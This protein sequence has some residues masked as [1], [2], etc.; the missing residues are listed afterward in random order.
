M[1]VAIKQHLKG[2]DIKERIGAGG[3]GAVYKAFQSTVGR[4]VAIKIILPG[5]SNQPDFIRRFESEAQ[6]IAR[7]EHPHI[8]PLYD[9]W[10]DPEGAYLVMRWLRGGSLR[11]ALQNGAFE[12]HATA[13]LLDQ[14]A[15]ALSLAHRNHIIHRDIK[16]ANILLDEDGNAYLTDFGIAKDLN[17]A[18]N[19]T[20]AD[21]IVGSLD[22]ISP[23][24]ARSEPVTPR[25]DIY[26]LGV[27]LYEV[28]SG[29]HPFEN[30]SPI[31][32]LYKHINDPLPEITTLD[33]KI[34]REINR[35]IQ[36][37]TAKDPEQR[38]PD[39]LAFAADF[40]EA[41]G[42]NRTPTDVIE[43]LT[44]RE[45]EILQLI[46]DGLS[47]KEIAQKLTI[48]LSTVK[49][50]VYQIYDK[51]GVRSRV[52]AM[53][54]ARDLNLLAKAGENGTAPVPT[55]DFHP[56][57]PY[58]GLRAFQSADNQD[59]F[60]R[61]KVTAKLI[62]RL[63]EASDY[64]RF[65][66]VVGPSGSG[67]SS[68]VKAGLIPALWRG[69]LPGSEKWFVVEMLPGTRPLDELEIALTKVAA[70]QA[71]NLHEHLQ[72]DS[73]GL[74]RA[75]SLILPNDNSELVLVID[76]FEEVF[77][78]L[79]DETAR[80][81]LLELLYRAVTEPRSRVRVVITLR[82]D[83]YDRPLH[84]P[85]FGELVRTRLETIM[86]LSAEELERAITQPA[87]R[88]GVIFEAGLV[89]AIIGD[90]NYQPGALPLLQY[91]LTELFEQRKGRLLT[92]EAYQA[93]GGT[94][95]ALAKR[96]EEV[97]QQLDAD[98]QE[99]TR[100]MFL[101]L[102]TL[103]EGTEDTRRRTPRAELQALAP[104]ADTLDD[105]LDT[106]A[107]YRLFA[108]DTDPGTRSPTVEVAHEALLREWERLRQWL[109]DSRDEIK[110]QRQ[111][112]TMA[113]EWHTA[114]EDKSFLA[115]GSRLEQLAKWA[116]ET[117]L[118][119]T[120]RERAYL[121]ASLAERERQTRAE[122]ERAARET[123]L[124]KRSQTFLRG[125]VAVLLLATLG[126]FGLTGAAVNSANEA[127]NA[128]ATSD[129]N[130]LLAQKNAAEAQ[131][132]AL[133][134]G[135]QAA[136][137]QHNTDLAVALAMQAVTLDP[138]SARAQTAL[139][140]AAYAP[141]TIRRYTNHTDEVEGVAISPDGRTFLSSSDDKTI[142]LQDIQTGAI[143]RR[144][145]GHKGG[146]TQVVF[147]PDGRMIASGSLD[148]TMI[149]WDV[150][151][152]QIIRQFED[153]GSEIYAVA[154]SPDGQ[155]VFA[156]GE[157][158][159][160]LE[161]NVDSGKI[162]QRFEGHSGP[163]RSMV[164]SRD[165][166]II[167]SASADTTV[168]IWDV[169][170]GQIIRRLEQKD[171]TDKGGV[172]FVAL[173]PDE[174]LALSS[175]QASHITLW[176]LTT[177]AVLR[178]IESTIGWIDSVLFSPDGRRVIAGGGTSAI[179]IWDLESGKK[180]SDF[181]GHTT[182]VTAMAL[183]ADGSQ[184]LSSSID[185]T[186]RLW[187]LD[188]GQIIRRFAGTQAQGWKV[189][190]SHDGRVALAASEDGTARLWDM[191]TG[192]EIWRFT[193]D[194]PVTTLAFS[195]DSRTALIG[196]GY[197]DAIKIEPGHLILWDVETGQEIQRF[198]GHPFVVFDVE[199]SP[200]G[201]MAASVGGGGTMI[202]WDVETGQEIQRFLGYENDSPYNGDGIWSVEFSPDGQTI[203]TAMPDGVLIL[204][205]VETGQEIQRY[206]RHTVGAEGVVFTPD[207]QRAL[208]SGWD[209]TAILWDVSTGKLLRQ[210]THHTGAVFQTQL[211]P[212]GR[213]AFSGSGDGT[214][215]L[216]DIETGD[217]FRRYPMA[218]IY[219][220][221]FS[222]DGRDA[223]VGFTDGSLA[224]WRIDLT[225]D[226]LLTWTRANRYIPELTCDQRA[227]YRLEPLCVET[228][229]P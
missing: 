107:S 155:Y 179:E 94:V 173:S 53:V 7:L 149:V 196:T 86:P 132:V 176:D 186:V 164:V 200:D 172:L 193:G 30:I 48:T 167:L 134:A 210:F 181:Y 91:A 148:A 161:W 17:L 26:S 119:L 142:L 51:L 65:L 106:F 157:N 162:V 218:G 168:I 169:Q 49:W 165:G 203:L 15:G 228:I 128:R 3:F 59:F 54:R 204:W 87:E 145:E 76:Q 47:N 195:P 127:Q 229:N 81:H 225:L 41:V 6:L 93:I 150:Q 117:K 101:R 104:D 25:T 1:D 211:T 14:I 8:T 44:P 62:K 123:Q 121:D 66:A 57:N 96:A 130:A 70:N 67:K 215:T 97:F 151:T 138:T 61:E 219:M 79:D 159:K 32:R 16:P 114:K 68:L 201:R 163:I 105:I 174:S 19:H 154:F 92:R 2:Y 72:R 90:V 147:S 45:H 135:S 189:A 20:Q 202:L 69:D 77:T 73:F 13:L 122:Q 206:E 40:R 120:P 27:T 213:Y 170:T 31:E 144:F 80:V 89:A 113:Q 11:D 208:S 10:R 146:T 136:L 185:G 175:D 43:L 22:Y 58:K 187:G 28:I 75:A 78:L 156:G 124:E 212:D 216:W 209:S 110:L 115:S 46:I 125:L 102:V 82:A 198:I 214:T 24:Q 207:G 220:S 37:A 140:E 56:E 129:A 131:N 23:E 109:N 34:A 9:Y 158:A 83:F 100:Q 38:Y 112:Q 64:S 52:Q 39:A 71:G 178:E 166:R 88:V 33:A 152:G 197:V 188:A 118:M 84:Y 4:E 223:F 137:G 74:V 153:Y 217:V 221:A 143:L 222:P 35:V 18:G 99:L 55:E 205:D 95:G 184:L 111:L 98:S 183:T 103:G 63:S 194:Q 139:S 108:L 36:Q 177:G 50:Y 126:A 226:D 199:F 191:A 5:L 29:H 160:L 180:L 171:A 182:G 192:Q 227:L 133:V 116:A 190:R 85:Q 12:L 21:A 42:F 224:L 60:G 141:G